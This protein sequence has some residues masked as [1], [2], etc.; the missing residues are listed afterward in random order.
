MIAAHDSQVISDSHTCHSDTVTHDGI[1]RC[2]LGDKMKCFIA[3]GASARGHVRLEFPNLFNLTRL[4]KFVCRLTSGSSNMLAPKNTSTPSSAEE[5][6]RLNY[7]LRGVV[8]KQ[9]P[10]ASGERALSTSHM[11]GPDPLW[12]GTLFTMP[13]QLDAPGTSVMTDTHVFKLMR[14]PTLASAPKGSWTTL[15]GLQ[16]VDPT[17]EPTA[18]FLTWGPNAATLTARSTAGPLVVVP[19]SCVESI[20]AGA[21]SPAYDLSRDV[22][23][24]SSKGS[25]ASCCFSLVLKQRPVGATGGTSPRRTLD[26]IA[27]T[28]PDAVAW[29][30]GLS[31][32][33][34]DADRIAVT[35][36]PR[37][38]PPRQPS[39]AAGSA[40]SARSTTASFSNGVQDAQAMS[41]EPQ[42]PS[43]S[44]SHGSKEWLNYF[45]SAV[46]SAVR[47]ERLEDVALAFDDGA[48]Y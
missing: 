30:L 4:F 24:D 22:A 42:V 2:H 39:P 45:R 27:H 31:R 20:A 16:S 28:V 11:P 40:S 41:D 33:L 7:A 8:P 35:A 5:A 44:T 46:F 34:R 3:E 10:G 43:A 15:Q 14:A 6:L 48:S 12:G 13:R 23:H 1:T 25:D 17:L 36:P 37:R 21:A 32:A 9:R 47:T 29:T 18:I 38:A 26:L 19:L